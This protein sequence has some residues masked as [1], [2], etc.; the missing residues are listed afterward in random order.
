MASSRNRNTT[1]NYEFEMQELNRFRNH[2]LY[3]GS[4]SNDTTY[5]PGNGL[6]GCK[7]PNLILSN[8]Y[9]DIETVLFGI[10]STNLVNPKKVENFIFHPFKIL[11]VQERTKAILPEPLVV[12]K[13]NRPNFY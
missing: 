12:S 7:N 2:I 5:Y 1:G 10:G 9:A 3:K 13:Y 8:N 11:D 4:V 6:L